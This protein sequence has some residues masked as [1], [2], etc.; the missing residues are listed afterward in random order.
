VC[1]S[2]LNP[3][4]VKS[5]TGFVIMISGCPVIWTSKLQTET[6]LSTMQA[7]YVALS[8][9]M[10]DL[11]PFRNL[12]LEI[13]EH[14]GLTPNQLATIKSTVWEDNIGALT[15]ANLEPPRI[16]PRSK[17]FAIKYHWFRES[18]KPGE[19][20]IVKVDTDN[21]LADILTKGLTSHK[22]EFLRKKLS[23]W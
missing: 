19:I 13:C 7:E 22:F 3:A 16:T 6:A 10:R 9:G 5:R 23:G 14:I 17:H 8:T 20:E 21:Q 18:L 2:D 15:L 1:S 11:L 4:S 12:T